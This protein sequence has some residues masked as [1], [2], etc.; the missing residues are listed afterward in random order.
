MASVMVDLGN[1]HVGNLFVPTR[2][3][4]LPH[5]L[6]RSYRNAHTVQWVAVYITGG[7]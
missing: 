4:G 5:P 3:G 2:A 1:L 6:G 7:V